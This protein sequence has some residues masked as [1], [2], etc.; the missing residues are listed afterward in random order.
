LGKE[1]L[2]QSPLETAGRSNGRRETN[3]REKSERIRAAATSLFHKRGY[4]QTTV[5]AIAAAA[6]VAPGTLF[7]YAADKRDLLLQIVNDE[8]DL[9]TGDAFSGVDHEAPVVDQLIQLFSPRYDYWC[10]DPELSLVALAEAMVAQPGDEQPQS[11]FTRYH[12]RRDSLAGGL[13]DL[14]AEQQQRG[15][16]RAGDDPMLLAELCMS[17]HL[18]VIRAWLQGPAPATAAAVSQLRALFA[19]ALRGSLLDAR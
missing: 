3:R 8:L 13:R 1:S 14:L 10:V 19:L 5:H 12:R 16:L 6:K 9:L 18:S 4:R 7:L 11:Q 2:M 15:R 17:I